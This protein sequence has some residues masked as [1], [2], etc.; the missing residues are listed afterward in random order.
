MEGFGLCGA[1]N[2][3][4]FSRIWRVVAWFSLQM[5]ATF[6]AFGAFV[7]LWRS[8]CGEFAAELSFRGLRLH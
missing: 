7:L 6:L 8:K 4:N 2:A 1:P 5:R 3:R